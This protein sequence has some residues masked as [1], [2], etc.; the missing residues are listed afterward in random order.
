MDQISPGDSTARINFGPESFWLGP[1]L[2]A[3]CEFELAVDIQLR[4]GSVLGGVL[5]EVLSEHLALR[6]F[7]DAAAT[8]TDELTLVPMSNI[9]RIEIP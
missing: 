8:H 5:A 7:D 3:L 1:A 9:S 2:A 4:D 6:G